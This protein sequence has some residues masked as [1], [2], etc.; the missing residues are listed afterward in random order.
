MI[1]IKETK[2]LIAKNKMGAALCNKAAINLVITHGGK[3]LANPAALAT[4]GID[5]SKLCSVNKHPQGGNWRC[6]I[7]VSRS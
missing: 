4:F 6:D 2:R 3:D 1:M 5:G 7:F